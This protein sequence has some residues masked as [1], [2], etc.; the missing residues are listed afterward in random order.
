[1]EIKYFELKNEL[2]KGGSQVQKIITD[3]KDINI[4][5]NVLLNQNKISHE[6]NL[7][8]VFGYNYNKKIKDIDVANIYKITNKLI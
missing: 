4:F 8:S 5:F 1:M 2:Q 6:Y 7:K 3:K